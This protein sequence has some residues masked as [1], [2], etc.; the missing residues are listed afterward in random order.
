MVAVSNNFVGTATV[1]VAVGLILQKAAPSGRTHICVHVCMYLICV[2]VRVV[3]VVVE[4]VI[5]VFAV[6]VVVVVVVE[7]IIVVFVALLR[8]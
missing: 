5:V 6:A 3:L 2:C 4:D 8:N 7:V 1:V